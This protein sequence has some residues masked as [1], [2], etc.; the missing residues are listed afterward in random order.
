MGFGSVFGI[1]VR[2]SAAKLDVILVILLNL[3]KL[4]QMKF[5]EI[6]AKSEFQSNKL[7]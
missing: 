4:D 2:N 7:D 3:I 5:Y 1:F 6:R